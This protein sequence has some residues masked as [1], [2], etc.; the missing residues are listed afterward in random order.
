M[1]AS[2]SNRSWRFYDT[3]KP[4]DQEISGTNREGTQTT[5]PFTQPLRAGINGLRKAA[6]ATFEN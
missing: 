4:K 1:G 6:H 5:V 3:P 2:S